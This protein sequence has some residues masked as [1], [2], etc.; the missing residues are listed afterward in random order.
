MLISLVRDLTSGFHLFSQGIRTAFLVMD[1]PLQSAGKSP[2]Q[3]ELFNTKICH[4]P[5]SQKNPSLNERKMTGVHWQLSTTWNDFVKFYRGPTQ[6]RTIT[7]KTEMKMKYLYFFHERKSS[8]FYW[9]THPMSLWHL[10]WLTQLLPVPNGAHQDGASH[11]VFTSQHCM[12][13]VMIPYNLFNDRSHPIWRP[14][15]ERNRARGQY[16]I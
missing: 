5:S 6:P 14:L 10:Y 1:V 9:R 2:F 8:M 15:S 7:L 4:K 11:S 13:Q 3:S 16:C 12:E